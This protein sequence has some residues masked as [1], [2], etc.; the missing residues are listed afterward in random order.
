MHQNWKG[1]NKTLFAVDMI[2]YIEN[3]KESKRKNK[4]LIQYC[5]LIIPPKKL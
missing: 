1:R 5:I 2:L 3:P 4:K